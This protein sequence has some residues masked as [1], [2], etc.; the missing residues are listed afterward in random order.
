MATPQV[1]GTVG[2]VRE[3]RPTATAETVEKA[4]EQGA[5]PVAGEFSGELGA[6]RLNA[7]KTLDAAVLNR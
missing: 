3:T 4:I 2:L 5:E 6:G 1:T 7:D